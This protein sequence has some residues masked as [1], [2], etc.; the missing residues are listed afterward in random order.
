MT[1][2]KNQTYGTDVVEFVK[3]DETALLTV[4]KE[5]EVRYFRH[6]ESLAYP[7]LGANVDWFS[8]RPI[9]LALSDLTGWLLKGYTVVSAMS[10]PLYL[11]IQLKKPEAMIDADLLQVAEQAK[12]EYADSRYRRNAEETKRQ[13]DIS[14]TRKMREVESATAK[15]AA[16]ALATSEKDALD[17]LLAAYAKPSKA[18]AKKPVEAAV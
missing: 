7:Q 15:A 11:K 12:A 8:D 9:A 16:D 1:N 6:S 3:H 17:D 18:Q 5:A 10:R 4:L 13:I 2:T 14:V